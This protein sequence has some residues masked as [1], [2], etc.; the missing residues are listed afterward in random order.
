MVH[1]RAADPSIAKPMLARVRLAW[2]ADPHRWL[3]SAIRWVDA[4][5]RRAE[6]ITEFSDDPGCV[7]RIAIRHTETAVDLQDGEIPAGSKFVELHLY[8]DH[9][10]K[11]DTHGLKWGARFRRR[12]VA[13]LA[14]LA[15]ALQRDPQLQDVRAV[16]GRLASPLGRHRAQLARLSARFGFEPLAEDQ[17]KHWTDSLHDLGENIWL[18]ILGLAFGTQAH[19]HRSLRRWRGDVWISRERLIACFGHGRGADAPPGNEEG[20]AARSA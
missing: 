15:D 20:R 17:P 19:E 16:R 6:G 5:I 14:E 10:I 12:L 2:P 11:N 18:V 4:S 9:L 1:V 8:N 13:S 3:L 7:L